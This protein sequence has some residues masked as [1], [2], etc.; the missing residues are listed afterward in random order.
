MNVLFRRLMS[1]ISLLP[2]ASIFLIPIYFNQ[3]PE[4]KTRSEAVAQDEL[5][6][7]IISIDIAF[8]L[9]VLIGLIV[10]L[11]RSKAVPEGKRALWSILL[12][13][14]NMFIFPIFWF[15]YI[16]D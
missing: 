3:V 14:G 4:P 6:N 5:F 13:L 1:V 12:I 7:L 11:Y 16:R 9:T 8:I 15:L 10:F 2:M